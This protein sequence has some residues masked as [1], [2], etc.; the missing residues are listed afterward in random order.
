MGEAVTTLDGWYTY[1]DFR[2]LNWQAW[3]AAQPSARHEAL[4]QLL[5]F[6]ENNQRAQRDRQGAYGQYAIAGHK[7]DL[8]FLHMRPTLAALNQVK[9][10]FQKT[11][12]ADF[13]LPSYSY[14]SCVEL[15][16]YL[17]KPGVSV[18]LDPYLQSRLK[19]MLPEM[20]SICFYPM[21]KRRTGTDNWYM[22]SVEERRELMK[23]HGLIGRKYGD[24]VTQIITGSQGLDDWEWGVTLFA[25][26]PLQFKKLVYEMRFDEVSAR[27]AEFGA[28]YVGTRLSK[29]QWNRYLQV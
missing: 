10:E 15:S 9:S 4:A 11:Q 2:T 26:D 1:H 13:T 12:F 20:Q 22:L 17:A 16:S 14:I 23:S 6:A 21:N 27:F 28:F 18:D 19:P 29:L 24:V 25:E 5:A 7:A 3:R 8:L